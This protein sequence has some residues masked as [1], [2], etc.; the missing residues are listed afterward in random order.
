MIPGQNAEPLKNLFK[1]NQY[2]TYIFGKKEEIY[3]EVIIFQG[4]RL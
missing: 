1:S 3:F 2:S 4:N